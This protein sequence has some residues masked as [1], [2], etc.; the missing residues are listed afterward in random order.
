MVISASSGFLDLVIMGEQIEICTKNGKIQG[1]A[2]ISNGEK[3]PTLV[4][5]RKR[6]GKKMLPR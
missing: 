5:Q 4:S 3:N 2:A 1:V 6:K